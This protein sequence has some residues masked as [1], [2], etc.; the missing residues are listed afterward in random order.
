MREISGRSWLVEKLLFLF[1]FSIFVVPLD[2]FL[3]R[4]C[5]QCL[6]FGIRGHGEFLAVGFR[7]IQKVMPFIVG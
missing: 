3:P 5:D 6:T 2:F 4:L 1:N 7:L